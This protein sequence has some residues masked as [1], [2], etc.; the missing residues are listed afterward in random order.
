[1]NKVLRLLAIPLLLT[2]TLTLLVLWP[3]GCSSGPSGQDRVGYKVVPSAPAPSPET[4][5]YDQ[6]STQSSRQQSTPDQSHIRSPRPAGHADDSARIDTQPLS[7]ASGRSYQRPAK[8]DSPPRREQNGPGDE[9]RTP[10]LI[11]ET[12]PGQPR[13]IARLADDLPPS[14]PA[15]DEELWI[16]SKPA[17]HDTHPADDAPGSGGLVCVP[18]QGAAR[19]PVPLRHTDVNARVSGP[20]SSVTVTQQFHNP[21]SSKIEAVY[22]FPLPE[23]AAVSDF[24]MTVGDRRIRGVIRERE[25]AQRI[26]AQARSQG[27]VAS[28]LTQERPNIFTQKVANIE[29][30]RQ[31]DIAI[32]YFNTLTFA[33]GSYEFT[34]PMVVGPRFNP[35]MSTGEREF[36]VSGSGVGAVARGAQGASGQQAEVQYLRPGERSGHDIAL[37]VDID[38]GVP[39]ESVTSSSHVINVSRPD[40]S[41]ARVSLGRLDRIP[42]R[43]FVLRYR[44]A[45]GSVRSGMV[46]HTDETGTYFALTIVPPA[47][48]ESLPRRPL[49]LVCLIDCSGSMDGY[50]I[51]KAKAA[52]KRVIAQLRPQ[53]T[54]QVIRFADAPSQL[55]PHPLAATSDNIRRG[56]SYINSLKGAGGTYLLDAVRTALTLPRDP[57]HERIVCFLTD[58]YI[59]N[60][61]EIIAEIRQHLGSAHVF[62]FGVGSA[63]NRD[64]MDSMARVG[65]GAV[66]YVGPN[67]D[68]ADA[69]DPFV[70]RVM[71]A[72]LTNVS[73][74]FQ[75]CQ[76]ADVYPRR[77]PDL[78]VDRPVTVVGR[79]VGSPTGQIVIKGTPDRRDGS[80]WSLPVSVPACTAPHKAIAQIWART[81][82]AQLGDLRTTDSSPSLRHETLQTALTYNLVSDLTAFLAVDAAAHTQGT[83]GTTVQVPVPVP[84]GVRYDTT[85][86]PR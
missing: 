84:E 45:A 25:E 75:G 35:P 28:L 4:M 73:L 51:E 72:A 85:V 53:D 16:I 57:A 17:P 76:V 69:I 23:N 41:H 80:T 46:T 6:L 9:G 19:I 65:R 61:P 39:I 59:G 60:E 29:P 74:D 66:A 30:G 38:A 5:E 14:R 44:V 26:Y 24:V 13:T 18:A 10:T 71:H 81:K 33:D 7:E 11:L 56:T 32:T 62:S 82:L 58:G 49:E 79:F 37:S 63:V 12:A 68:V 55:A 15:F 22:V 31:I 43:D 40:A 20:V 50:P 52:A 36:G 70:N 78:F 3:L 27:F 8:P 48:L 83:Y 54:F 47:A 86:S 77:L 67:D 42:N 64:L 2:L 1:M 34:F 21:F